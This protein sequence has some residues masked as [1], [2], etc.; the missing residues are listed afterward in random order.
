MKNL[1][2]FVVALLVL[3]SCSTKP[4]I[5]EDLD[6]EE[7]PVVVE[8]TIYRSFFNGE[9]LDE[10]QNEYQ[11][12]G[13]MISNSKEARPQS[14]LGLADVVYEIA[15]ETYSITRFLA[16]F[17]SNHP[18]KVGPSR[19]ARIPF[20][21]MIQEWGLP[22]SHYGA[23]RHG[24]GDADSLIVEINPPRRFDGVRGINNEFFFRSTDRI[25]PHNAYFNSEKALVK[26]PELDYEPHFFF[27]DETNI[28]GKRISKLSLRYSA[29]TPVKYEYDSESNKY[30]RFIH[31]QPMMDA[32][33]NEQI[34]V[35]NIIVQHVPHKMVEDVHYVLVDFLGEGKAE[36]YINGSYEEGTW[37][38]ESYSTFTQ[39]FTS[40]GEPL[41]LLPGNTWIQLV[42]PN[43]NIT[44]E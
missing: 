20:V 9:L 4:V 24:Q 1:S 31:D 8:E 34:S 19:S 40:K 12:F 29:Y 30:K 23:A 6:L 38:K 3:A 16:I 22:F 5:E 43:V 14:G 33:T 2:I 10:E 27:D 39:F 36:F 37:K 44:K 13:I 18:D 35:T 41:V 11:A 25:A 7:P 21:R 15:V 17:A 42:H 32:Y 26:I 28:T